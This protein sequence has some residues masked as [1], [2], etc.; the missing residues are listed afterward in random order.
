MVIRDGQRPRSF[1]GD[2]CSSIGSVFML[3][4]TCIDGLDMR[5][6]ARRLLLL[7]VTAVFGLLVFDVGRLI[8]ATSREASI[9]AVRIRNAMVAELGDPSQ[10]NW[11]PSAM[12]G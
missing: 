11:Q 10:T 9:D 6:L 12:P 2:P 1:L 8:L 5:S 7:V 4:R 3:Q